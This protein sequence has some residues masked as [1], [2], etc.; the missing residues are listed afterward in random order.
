MNHLSLYLLRRS[1]PGAPN[2]T[3]IFPTSNCG[4]TARISWIE[5][6]PDAVVDR[7]IVDCISEVDE[8]EIEVAGNINSYE[9]QPQG[10]NYICSVV[11][12]NIDGDS[13]AGV[14]F[15]TAGYEVESLF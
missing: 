11:A 10:T 5:P 9:F 12:R 14:A 2:V 7:Y 6:D 8:F 15:F 1:C 13:P 4:D 3:A